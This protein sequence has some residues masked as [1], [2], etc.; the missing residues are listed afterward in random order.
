MVV[1]FI[2][3]HWDELMA[4]ATVK[5]RLITLSRTETVGFQFTKAAETVRQGRPVLVVRME[6]SSLIIAQFIEP[7][8]FTLEKEGRRRI[9]QYSGR[10]TPSIRKG[11]KWEDLDA[12]TVFDWK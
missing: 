5:S 8:F 6:P 3:A 11:D 4:G 10:V 2:W 12:L 9:L 7:L 1:P